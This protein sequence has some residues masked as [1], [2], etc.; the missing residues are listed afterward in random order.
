MYNE[1]EGKYKEGRYKER[2]YKKGDTKKDYVNERSVVSVWKVRRE[3]QMWKRGGGFC[4]FIICKKADAKIVWR[5][6]RVLDVCEGWEG[7]DSEEENEEVFSVLKI[8]F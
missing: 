3:V 6:G 4:R 1:S 2:R 8:L 7:K 5:R